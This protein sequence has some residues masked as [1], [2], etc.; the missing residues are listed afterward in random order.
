MH[1]RLATVIP[2]ALLKPGVKLRGP[3]GELWHIRAFVDEAQVVYRVWSGRRW[4]YHIESRI[5][6]DML[7]SSEQLDYAG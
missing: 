6:L 5:L 2:V 4:R 7:W 3:H 1:K